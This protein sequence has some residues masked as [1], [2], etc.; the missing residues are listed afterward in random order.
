[1]DFILLWNTI[2]NR[3]F[4]NQQLVT[5]SLIWKKT[6]RFNE[7]TYAYDFLIIYQIFQLEAIAIF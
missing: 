5:K 7:G 2:K 3:L 4:L 6:E 1:M